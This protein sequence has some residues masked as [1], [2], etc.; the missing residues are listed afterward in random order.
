MATERSKEFGNSKF[1]EV[2]CGHRHKLAVDEKFGIRVRTL[3]ALCPPDEWHSSMG[4]VNN[5]RAAEAFVWN[6]KEGMIA[7]FFHTETD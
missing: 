3:S 7:Q 1:R 4:F 5:V 2:H 6:Q